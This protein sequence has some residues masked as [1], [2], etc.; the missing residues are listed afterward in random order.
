MVQAERWKQL[1]WERRRRGGQEQPNK[2]SRLGKINAVV[3]GCGFR[4]RAGGWW[5]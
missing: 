4:R 2:Y 5:V 3:V 1:A